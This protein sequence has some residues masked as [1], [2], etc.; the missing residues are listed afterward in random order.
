MSFDNSSTKT[1]EQL[2]SKIPL[3]KLE[4]KI[5]QCDNQSDR[6]WWK[7]IYVIAAKS[8]KEHRKYD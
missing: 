3:N 4:K 1:I 5:D 2:T 8:R 6:E 7:Q